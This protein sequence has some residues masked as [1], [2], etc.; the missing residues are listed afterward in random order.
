MEVLDCV[1]N[2]LLEVQRKLDP[3]QKEFKDFNEQ[4]MKVREREQERLTTIEAVKENES[5]LF[6]L[7]IEMFLYSEKERK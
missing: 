7:L 2:R 6:H 5:F 4:C 1:L 3:I